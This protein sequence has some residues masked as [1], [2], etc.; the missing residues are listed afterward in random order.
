MREERTY[1]YLSSRYIKKG[2]E[3][4]SILHKNKQLNKQRE[5]QRKYYKENRSEKRCQQINIVRIQSNKTNKNKQRNNNRTIN[6][7]LETP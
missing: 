6:K 4:I 3:D 1:K 7:R 2:Y 5:H